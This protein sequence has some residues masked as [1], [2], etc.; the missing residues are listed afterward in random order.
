M[1]EIGVRVIS[2]EAEALERSF[3]YLESVD[4][5]KIIIAA[6]KKATKP[7]VSA[8][9]TNTP[10]GPVRKNRVPGNLKKSI[11]LTTY[12]EEVA[13]VVGARKTRGF[14]GHHGIIV[15]EG[16][17]DRFYITKKNQVKHRTGKMKPTGRYSHFLQR[18]VAAT[19][20]QVYDTVA[21]EWYT[22]I[23][24]YLRK[25]GRGNN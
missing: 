2:P 17:V 6:L 23:D 15:E 13:V 12:R 9:I 8:A 19:E 3:K 11:G 10:V 14:K 4:K 25:N 20:K 24:K 5:K 21:L 7:T 22:A 1:S 18:A 16:T